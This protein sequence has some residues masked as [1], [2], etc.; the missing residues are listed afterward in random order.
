M[1]RGRL[2][3]FHYS[4]RCPCRWLWRGWRCH[5]H[6]DHPLPVVPSGA[7]KLDPHPCLPKIWRDPAK[8]SCYRTRSSRPPFASSRPVVSPSLYD[9]QQRRRR[10][11]PFAPLANQRHDQRGYLRRLHRGLVR[12]G[13]VTLVRGHDRTRG[14]AKPCLG[15]GRPDCKIRHPR[16]N[17]QSQIAVCSA[18]ATASSSAP[19]I[20]PADASNAAQIS[21]SVFR[22]ASAI[23]CNS[24]LMQRSIRSPRVAI[25]S[26]LVR[27]TGRLESKIASSLFV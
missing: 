1:A 12:G 10:A 22:P 13:A 8:R 17:G 14:Q 19:K 5:R 9:L 21:D 23:G 25:S 11:G 27:T 6:G 24:R 3:A 20:R 26:M 18:C 15:G 16:E 2:R 4:R 7:G